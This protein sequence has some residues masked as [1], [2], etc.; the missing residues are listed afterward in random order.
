MKQFIKLIQSGEQNITMNLDKEYKLAKI[1]AKE[2]GNFLISEKENISA[3]IF[4]KDK[5]IKLQADIQTEALIKSI[6]EKD[7]SF[8]I[9]GEESGASIKELGETYWVVDPL[10]G[11]ANFARNI[12]ISC[13]SIALIDNNQPVL[14]VIYD[15]NH[16]DMYSGSKYHKA[17]MNDLEIKVSQV[18]E[19]SLATIVTGLPAK[20]DFSD[21]AMQKMINDFQSWKKV[22]MI[23]SAAMAS[24]Y[25]AS[26]KA[27]LYKEFGIYLWDIAAGA[28]IVEAAGGKVSLLNRNDAYQVDAFFSNEFLENEHS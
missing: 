27:D 23:G 8:P 28:A 13:V 26:G 4:S 1:A 2:A 3:T 7:S 14:G 22:R 24:V 12:P 25:V 6:L 9:L 15:F 19:K 20:T 21:T 17:E 11:T 16:D 5:D 10:D 18:Q